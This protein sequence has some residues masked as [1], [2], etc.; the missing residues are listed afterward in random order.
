MGRALVAGPAGLGEGSGCDHVASPCP[1]GKCR[2]ITEL[3]QATCFS[4]VW[5]NSV[6]DIGNWCLIC[7]THALCPQTTA[8]VSAG[9]NHP[10]GSCLGSAVT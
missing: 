10:G 3:A 8:R 1:S 2:L 7:G 6:N 4:R 5:E 9:R